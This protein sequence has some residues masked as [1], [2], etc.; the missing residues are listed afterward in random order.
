MSESGTD[1]QR[2][3]A[4]LIIP[5]RNRSNLLLC[6]LV[7][8]NTFVNAAISIMLDDMITGLGGLVVS[9]LI[10][11]TFG[12]ILPQ[13]IFSRFALWI[14]AHSVV[15]VYFFMIFVFPIAWPISL[16]LDLIL[17]GDTDRVYSRV[18][19]QKLVELHGDYAIL[20]GHSGLEPLERKYFENTL[21]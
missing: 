17:R 2:K 3:Y 6:T 15:L 10:I 1:D 20:A 19:L 12:E 18:E 16:I 7:I 21:T 4:K 9:T 8:S 13:A 11:T 5:L 14:G